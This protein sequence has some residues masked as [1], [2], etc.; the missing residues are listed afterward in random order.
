MHAGKMVCSRFLISLE[1]SLSIAIDT[2]RY[3][4]QQ[5]Q[6]APVLRSPCCDSQGYVPLARMAN[7]V[8]ASSSCRA[9]IQTV[10]A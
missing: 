1:Q 8:T 2:H 6:Q 7:T 5:P 9:F 4:L 3:D 10:A